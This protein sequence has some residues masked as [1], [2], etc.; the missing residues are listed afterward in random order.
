MVLELVRDI[1]ASPST[2]RASIVNLHEDISA[3]AVLR[4]LSLWALRVT[5]TGLGVQF[6]KADSSA[7]RA[8]E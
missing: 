2:H 1:C 8:S 5:E 6:S 7:L 4:R 3:C